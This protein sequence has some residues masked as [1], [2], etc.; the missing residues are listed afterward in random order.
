M[1]ETNRPALAFIRRR[2]DVPLRGATVVPT[3]GPSMS[4]AAPAIARSRRRSLLRTLGPGLVTGAADDD[5]SGIGTFSQVGAQFGYQLGWTMLFSYPL[6]AV[7]QQ[8]SAQI[9]RVTGAGIARNLRR[10]YSPWLL[11][12]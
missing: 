1:P 9:G 3:E 4:T 7:T 10:H 6:M 11:R 12:G 5:P 8:I 2:A